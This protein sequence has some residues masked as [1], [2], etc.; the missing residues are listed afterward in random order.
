MFTISTLDIVGPLGIRRCV[1][2]KSCVG[3]DWHEHKYDHDAIFIS[4]AGLVEYEYEENG[5]LITGSKEYY[6]SEIAV[7]KA[8]VK[9]RV[10]P[11][12]DKVVW[13]CA[14]SHR[15][16]DGMVTERYVG[17]LEAYE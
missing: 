4:G 13:I 2:D 7:I 12:T 16:F 1:L 14:F 9:H 8:G 10:I 5:K 3:Y 17:N 6:Q 11:T 15:D